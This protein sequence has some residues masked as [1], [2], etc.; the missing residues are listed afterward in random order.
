MLHLDVDD[1]GVEVDGKT[2][3]NRVSGTKILDCFYF[4]NPPILPCDGSGVHVSGGVEVGVDLDIDT[5]WQR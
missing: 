4:E 5:L 2:M 3:L 1:D